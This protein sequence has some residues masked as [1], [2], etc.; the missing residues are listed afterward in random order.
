MEGSWGVRTV[1][2]GRNQ[3]EGRVVSG[4]EGEGGGKHT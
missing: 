2:G 3:L 1:G 4:T